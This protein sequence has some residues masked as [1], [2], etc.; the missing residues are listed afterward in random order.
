MYERVTQLDETI[1]D[2]ERADQRRLNY[3]QNEVSDPSEQDLHRF[4]DDGGPYD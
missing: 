1:T 4:M 3:D 2:Q